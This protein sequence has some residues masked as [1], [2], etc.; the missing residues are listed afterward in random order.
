MASLRIR[1]R[2][3]GIIANPLSV[4]SAAR[5]LNATRYN[6]SPYSALVL[7][8]H[9]APTHVTNFI[10]S[11]DL[12]LSPQKIQ[13]AILIHSALSQTC[14]DDFLVL[15]TAFGTTGGFGPAN[16][17]LVWVTDTNVKPGGGHSYGYGE[18]DGQSQV[19]ISSTAT[20][21]LAARWVFVLELG[22]VQF[23]I[24]WSI[25]GSALFVAVISLFTRA[26]TNDSK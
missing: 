9:L 22:E 20:G 25:I 1:S 15:Q 24:I 5:Q 4:R 7:L 23:P 6:F 11:F 12:T 8:Q 2:A 10:Y 16:H 18:K 17:I 14:E 3:Y 19:S 26:S 13:N 21:A